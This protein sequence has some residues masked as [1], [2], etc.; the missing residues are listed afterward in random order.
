VQNKKLSKNLAKNCERFQILPVINSS[1]GQMIRK[2]KSI[3]TSRI[4]IT[5]RCNNN[6]SHCY[7]NLPSQDRQAQE[8]ELTLTQIKSLVDQARSLG[9]LWC[10]ITGG[11]P[12]L[13]KD[14]FDIFFYLKKRGFLVSIYTNANLITLEHVLFFR[15]FPPVDIEV[16]VYG[17]TQG[18]YERVTRT[19]GSFAAFKRGLDLLWKNGIKVRLKAMALRSNIHELPAIFSYCRKHTKDYFRFDPF[20]HLRFDKDPVRNR[21]IQLERL[22]PQE[23]VAIE[24]LDQKRLNALKDNCE[25]LIN[26]RFALGNCDHLF[27]CGVG[28][29]EFNIGYSGLLRLCPSLLHPETVCDL[30][31]IGL[32]DALKMLISKVRDMRSDNEAFLKKCRKC[33]I[34]NLCLWCPANAYLE[35]GELDK[36]VEY[37]CKVAHARE[38]AIK[39]N[40]KI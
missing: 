6:C 37:F 3:V 2:R 24:G 16:T 21:E 27:H 17:V 25:V 14:F 1:F 34:T 29:T 23:I 12:L 35:T 9:S 18:T 13:R 4:E 40:N 22:S 20:L 28:T 32:K 10:C 7:I 5:A 36:P 31:K 15:R 39:L 38:E 11:E 26:P 33:P 19:P 30:K 8:S